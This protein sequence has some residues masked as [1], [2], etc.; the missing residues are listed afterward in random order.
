MNL[1]QLHVLFDGLPDGMKEQLGYGDFQTCWYGC[2]GLDHRFV[3]V[4]NRQGPIPTQLKPK[5][6]FLYGSI[7]FEILIF[8]A[9]TGLFLLRTVAT[10][11]NP[12]DLS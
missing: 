1:D 6:F 2:A 4:V 7:L 5:L 3:D 8:R 9:G 12:L 10:E 11:K